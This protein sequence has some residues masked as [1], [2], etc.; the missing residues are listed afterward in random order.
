MCI[1]RFTGQNIPRKIHEH[2]GSAVLII[3]TYNVAMLDAISE[4]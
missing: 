3:K 4:W 2:G 1:N